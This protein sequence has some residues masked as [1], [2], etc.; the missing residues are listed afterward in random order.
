MIKQ[1]NLKLNAMDA[2]HAL[3]MHER[4]KIIERNNCLKDTELKNLKTWRKKNN[5]V[6]EKSFEMKI[7]S[8]RYD[9]EIYSYALQKIKKEDIHFFIPYVENSKWFKVFNEAIDLYEN[10]EAKAEDINLSHSVT[11]F[12][13]WALE[14]FESYFRDI[15]KTIIFSVEQIIESLL[16]N[17]AQELTGILNRSAV[18]EMHIMKLEEKLVG[19]T[20]E[21]RFIS[22]I[23]QQFIN[24]DNMLNFYKEYIT[25]TRLLTTRT[26]FFV[27]NIIEA[28]K[29]FISDYS[30]IKQK[31]NIGSS[32][33]CSIR[34]G[35]GDT[36]Q[37]GHTVIRFEFD[38]KETVF[39]KPKNLEVALSY[40]QLIDWINNKNEMLDLPKYNI[41]C[42]N[43]YSWEE[44]ISKKECSNHNEVE[45]FYERFGQL[46]G[47]MHC[48]CGSDFHYE[49]LI[50]HGAYPYIID[51]ETLFQQFP[52]LDFP[53][54]ANVEVKKEYINS[55]MLTA[56]VPH[57]MYRDINDQIGID[58]SG[59]N[60]KKQKLPY[61]VLA[62]KEILTDNM[63]YDY[64]EVMIENQDNRP[65]LN[66]EAVEFKDYTEYIYKGFRTACKFIIKHKAELV[67]E[68][69]ILVNFKKKIVRVILR[70]TQR[71]VNML[72]EGQHPD[73]TRDA[74]SREYLLENMWS[75]AFVDKSIIKHEIQDMLEGD[76][77]VF[78]N[79]PE[80]KDLIDSKGNVIKNY[81][82][83][84]AYDLVI[85]RISNLNEEELEKQVSWL[86]I[87]FGDYV[88]NH[89]QKYLDA[90]IS[91]NMDSPM[92]YS[93]DKLIE[94][95][96][97][98]GD[99]LLDKAS[100][101]KDKKTVNWMD[102]TIGR[103]DQW[104]I[105]PLPSDFYDGLSGV[106]LF[107]YYLYEVTK[108][109][110]YKNA[111][112]T[113]IET[114]K[115]MP[116][117]SN[118]ISGY[119]GQ[120]SILQTLERLPG[121]ITEF[122]LFKKQMS[123]LEENIDNIQI[124]DFLSGMAGILNLLI[125]LYNK[126]KS[127]EI[128]NLAKKYGDRLITA[129]NKE[130]KEKIIGG[131]A[132]GSSGISYVLFKLN[133]IS[134]NKRYYDTALEV[135]K[136]DRTFFDNKEN[137]W[138][139]ERK[140][141]N[142]YLHQWCH[143]SVG[144]GMSRILTA[145]FYKD[146]ESEKEIQVAV[147]NI[148]KVGMKAEDSVCHGNM[149]DIEFLLCLSQF[150]SDNRYQNAAVSIMNEVINI[151]EKRNGY[152]LRDIPG[153]KAIGLFTGVSGIGYQMLRLARPNIV[154][155]LLY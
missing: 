71:Y 126:Q 6:S 114:V 138:R 17:L 15:D 98:I 147:E 20:P 44:F 12:I 139:D 39:F 151:K 129:L 52:Q 54:H 78:F 66:G 84:A 3:W 9:K 34:P 103:N 87:S 49:N 145:P 111:Y 132:H 46:L 128:L 130:T 65:I 153:F 59:L 94:E 106:S 24:D 4:Y 110:K 26:I 152:M 127:S 73:Y 69:G 90:R 105:E 150:Y 56:L 50:A 28:I 29:A 23:E 22:F 80:S 7:E 122:D 154:P 119:Y 133:D 82:E 120:T 38:S 40:N 148:L 141:E 2:V 1:Q 131:M 16:I 14:K 67:Q 81:F 155:S 19:E 135:L 144:I 45:S 48:I 112:I 61:K 72:N 125:N 30:L 137:A 143:G 96:C 18:L 116:I 95:A 47:I 11:I 85:K 32:K 64:T 88:F 42:R 101:S 134:P 75:Y 104:G 77:P 97:I 140:Q 107:F 68:D 121:E 62:P 55:V 43:N 41:I 25:L 91:L 89:S 21:Q 117:A 36:H 76:I 118:V 146:S 79:Y 5:I 53:D 58:L 100:Y 74:L 13:V 102:V 83:E 136:I 31:M 33:I 142:Y 63:V 115:N 57:R 99:E 108:E 149:G 124:S 93:T 35:M 123:L 27:D 10:R 92:S 109:D 86:K 70:A 8:E 37:Q 60:G 51:L 113:I